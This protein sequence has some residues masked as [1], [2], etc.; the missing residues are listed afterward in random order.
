MH[1]KHGNKR[2]GHWSPPPEGGGGAGTSP[3]LL[4]PQVNNFSGA[5]LPFAFL[6][7]FL[8]WRDRNL[9][10][11]VITWKAAEEHCRRDSGIGCHGAASAVPTVQ[12]AVPGQGGVVGGSGSCWVVLG[13]GFDVGNGDKARWRGVAPRDTGPPVLLACQC[14]GRPPS[15]TPWAIL[16]D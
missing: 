6:R 3:P 8:L 4:H 16:G 9:W 2:A 5:P 15:L 7:Q 12:V 13:R 11:M 10:D 1:E 14:V